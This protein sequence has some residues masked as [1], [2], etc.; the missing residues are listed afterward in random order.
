MNNSS[1]L[2]ESKKRKP[3]QISTQLPNDLIYQ[4]KISGIAYLFNH[5]FRLSHY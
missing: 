3:S 5:L 1:V 4:T 2:N